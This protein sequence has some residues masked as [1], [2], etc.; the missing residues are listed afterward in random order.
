MQ[1]NLPEPQETPIEYSIDIGG[2]YGEMPDA[3]LMSKFEETDTGP[4]EDLYDN[5][6]RGLIIDWR[7]DA[8]ATAADEP[9]GRVNQNYG[10]LQLQYYGHRGDANDPAHPEAFLDFAGSDHVDP[11][12]YTNDPDM[13][14]LRAQENARMRFVRFSADAQES[15]TGGGRSEGK[16]M[17]DNQSIFRWIRDRLKVFSTEKDGRREGLRGSWMHVSAKSNQVTTAPRGD[18]IEPG[19][20]R[21]AGVNNAVIIARSLR[22]TKAFRG[23]CTDQEFT[24]HKYSQTGRRSKKYTTANPL[25]QV[26]PDGRMSESDQSRCYKAIGV[27]LGQLVKARHDVHH[28]AD[29]GDSGMTQMRR[30]ERIIDD[31]SLIL[32]AIAGEQSWKASDSSLLLKTAMPGQPAK[33]INLVSLN[34]LLPA[35]HY[36]VADKMY[37]GLMPG[38][39]MSK[40]RDEICYDARNPNVRET[41]TQH[42]KRGS[43]KIDT[44]VN[45]DVITS[46]I[47]LTRRAHNYKAA[48]MVNGDKRI[49]LFNGEDFKRESRRGP[50]YKNHHINYKITGPRDIVVPTEFGDNH[51]KERLLAP[52]G[53]KSRARRYTDTDGREGMLAGLT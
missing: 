36:L 42:Y 32:R 45:R 16:A 46:I 33:V 37:K 20:H 30:H 26:A 1:Y 12:G 3:M 49:R 15:I 13:S 4:D 17:A 28:D 22:D 47:D 21:L 50:T 14:R 24:V 48:M 51:H 34:H 41:F 10:R 25:L 38:A 29:Y 40:I 5:Y 11:R 18:Y 39:D 9:R 31:L 35:T 2:R 27:L 19:K 43:D 7:P 44:G 8:P 23:D 6:A 52:M 53:V